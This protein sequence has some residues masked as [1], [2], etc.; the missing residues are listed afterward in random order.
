[1]KKLFCLM[2]ALLLVLVCFAA[3][4]PEKDEAD[5]TGAEVTTVEE[6][7]GS[8]A[9]SAEETTAEVT[10]TGAESVVEETTCVETAAEATTIVEDVTTVAEVTE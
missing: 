5:T 2:F 8:V 9:E 10:G 6:V 1:M 7:T 4:K 3:C